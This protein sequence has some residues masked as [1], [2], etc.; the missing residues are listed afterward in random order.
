MKINQEN[1]EIF[2]YQDKEL[3]SSLVLSS[4]HSGNYY[5]KDFLS[6]CQIDPLKLCQNEDSLVD[7]LFKFGLF[8]CHIIWIWV[9]T[10]FF[11]AYNSSISI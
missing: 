6:L 5:P 9:N 7:K 10:N 3:Y 8:A 4:P 2:N 11:S 1:I